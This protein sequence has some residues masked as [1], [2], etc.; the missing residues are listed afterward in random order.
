MEK[1]IV[2]RGENLMLARMSAGLSQR[3]LGTLTG[4][5]DMFISLLERNRCRASQDT[6]TRLA[7]ALNVPK[8]V[9]VTTLAKTNG[10]DMVDYSKALRNLERAAKRS[11][12]L[13]A[14]LLK[15]ANKHF[16]EAEK[17][18]ESADEIK[19]IDIKEKKRD[20]KKKTK[21]S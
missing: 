6:V 20:G 7:E 14:A 21:Q 4:R 17:Y 18:R 1:G 12:D 19:Q 11:D 9:L 2:I 10:T 15:Q 8:S 16:E 5:T 3:A 13:G